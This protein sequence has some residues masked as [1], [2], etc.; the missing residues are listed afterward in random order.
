MID[1]QPLPGLYDAEHE[2]TGNQAFLGH[3]E[4]AD[5]AL[6]GGVSLSPNRRHVVEDH[7]QILIDQR[8]QQTL[9]DAI[10]LGLMI[11]QGI[12]AAQQMLMGDRVGFNP[13]HRDRFQ[14]AQE[15]QL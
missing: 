14:P 6:L 3:A 8:A 2:L 15:A 13:W 10:D 1:R 9:D 7:R 12:H 5:L 4:P 11:D